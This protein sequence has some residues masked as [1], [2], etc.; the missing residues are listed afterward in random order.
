MNIQLKFKV[1]DIAFTIV[2]HSIYKVQIKRIK[3]DIQAGGYCR[4]DCEYDGGPHGFGSAE[5]KY[6]F[7]TKEELLASL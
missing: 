5:E 7:G 2:G 1:G 6:L 4:I 3:I